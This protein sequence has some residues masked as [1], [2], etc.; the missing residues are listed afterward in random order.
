MYMYCTGKSWRPRSANTFSDHYHHYTAKQAVETD[1]GHL[2]RHR[3]NP[4]ASSPIVRI[5]FLVDGYSYM[6][7]PSHFLVPCCRLSM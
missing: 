3:H 4:Y 7:G 2:T 5:L 1:A 6:L